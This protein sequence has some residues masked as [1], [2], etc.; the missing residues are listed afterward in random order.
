MPR[1]LDGP[2]VWPVLESNRTTEGGGWTEIFFADAG[3]YN[4]TTIDY[5]VTSRTLRND[6]TQVLVID[7]G[8]VVERGPEVFNINMLRC[9][10]CGLCEEACPK[11]AIYLTDRILPSN[12]A[13]KSFVY[14]KDLLVEGIEP[15]KRVD[16]SE[17]KKKY[18]MNV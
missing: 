4:S 10:F 11:D 1:R 9:I 7:H 3:G 5:Q 18:E 8:A 17:R 2:G 6:A 12:Y 14:G 13:R 16:V 15:D